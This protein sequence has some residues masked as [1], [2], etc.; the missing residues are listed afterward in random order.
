MSVHLQ[1]PGPLYPRGKSSCYPVDRR[2]GWS[3]NCSGRWELE[4]NDFPLLGIVQLVERDTPV[5]IMSCILKKLYDKGDMDQ[6]GWRWGQIVGCV[7]IKYG[8]ILASWE[9]VGFSRR[10]LIYG[11]SSVIVKQRRIEHVF[12]RTL[13][14]VP[15]RLT[16]EDH[17]M[18]QRTA[19]LSESEQSS[20]K[21]LA[22]ERNCLPCI[23]SSSAFS[24]LCS[25]LRKLAHFVYRVAR[26]HNINCTYQHA[27]LHVHWSVKRVI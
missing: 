12:Q 7:S 27:T 25:C 3:Q 19:R 15:A 13:I 14:K 1:T 9:T 8:E 11:A 16:D 2:L 21:V 24:Q 20:L 18:C 6:C 17:A 4:R 26:T 10:T 23:T 5:L 22:S